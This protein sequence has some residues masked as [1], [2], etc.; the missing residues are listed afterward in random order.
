MVKNKIRVLLI[1][2]EPFSRDELRHL[3][4]T[5]PD[6]NVI[7]EAQS[8]EEALEKIIHLEPD[9][10]FLDIEMGDK[11]GLELACTIQ[12]L[13]KVPFIVFATAYPDFAVKAFRVDALDYVLKPFDE[14]QIFDAIKRIRKAFSAEGEQNGKRPYSNEGLGKLAVQEDETIHYIDPKEIDY[15]YRDGNVTKVISHGK[16]FVTRYLLKDIEEKL[17]DHSFF[18]THKGFIVNLKQVEEMTPWFHGAYQLKLLNVKEEIPV[19]RHYVKKL[20]LRLE[21]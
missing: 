4:L 5:Y 3:L 9:A 7:G 11:N 6:F 18:R 19:S 21:I 13:K 14:E 2:D 16:E 17:A 8:A 10:L 1:D 15:I 20:R 12:K